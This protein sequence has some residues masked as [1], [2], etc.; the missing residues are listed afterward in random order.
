[1]NNLAN[2]R[3]AYLRHAANQKIDWYPWSE[4][5]F[6]KARHEDKPVF[7]SSGAVW[8]HWCHVMA[9]ESFEDEDTAQLLNKMFVNIK[10]DRDERPDID[11][12]YQQAVAA[13]SGNGGWPLSV[14]LTPEKE[15]F[16]GGTYF[17]PEDRMGM[18]GFKKVIVAV[19][20]AFRTKRADLETFSRK[21]LETLK[22]EDLHPGAIAE[23]MLRDAEEGMIDLADEANGGFGRAPKFP[24]PGALEFLVR[25]AAL[26][27]ASKAAIVARRMLT[28]MADGGMHDHLAGGFHRY[29]T[30]AHWVIPHFEK[31]VDDNAGLLE[32]YA[33]GF[34]VFHDDHFRQVALG[35]IRFTR[36]VLSDSE[37]GFYA[38]QDADVTPDDEGGY[39]TWTDDDF[40]SCLDSVEYEVLSVYLLHQQGSMHHDPAKRVLFV[41]K[42]IEQTA[43]DLGRGV[44]DVQRIIARGKEKLLSCRKKRTPP[45]IDTARYP[46]L[47]GMVISAYFH[48][49]N[50]LGGDDIRAFAVKSLDRTLRERVH[51]G[52]I[53]HAEGIPGLLDDYIFFVDALIS[54][55]EATAELRYLNESERVMNACIDKFYDQKHGGFFDTEAEVLGARF[56]KIEDVPHP[57]ANAVAV[58][59]LLKLA[60]ITGRQ[61]YRDRAE[62]SLKLFAD[63]AREINVHAGSYFCALDTWFNMIKLTVEADPGS[64]LARAARRMAGKV[65]TVI[66]YGD[67]HGQI[68]PCRQMICMEP[69]KDSGLLEKSILRIMG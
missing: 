54:G 17:P 51:D 13:M 58:K 63:L 56:K 30:D 23:T 15:P 9:A 14:F 22:H 61:V 35:I 46:S 7:L 28:A 62:H 48:A 47:N 21:V 42:S 8:C 10:L 53:S 69:V 31:M 25:R 55:Y 36:E 11:R 52:N 41:E 2:E 16:Y 40:R 18:P 50:V 12:R 68:I 33:D 67:D 37:G 6:E 3:S 20:D 57:S 49:Y 39:F 43:H 38:S 27:P 44:A 32:N 1:M 65:H 64:E 45:Y 24:M 4:D 29:S 26:D 66:V 60:F 5:A 34:A 59:V 19:H